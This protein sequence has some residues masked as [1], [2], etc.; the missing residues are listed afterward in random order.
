MGDL[1]GKDLIISCLDDLGVIGTSTS[2]REW[3]QRGGKK[4]YKGKG[5]SENCLEE[6]TARAVCSSLNGN[7]G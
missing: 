7:G 6:K 1:Y 3:L 4:K 5:G 2:E